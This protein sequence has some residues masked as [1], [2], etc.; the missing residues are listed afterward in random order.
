[1][2]LLQPAKPVF[3]FLKSLVLFGE[4][5]RVAERGVWAFGNDWCLVYLFEEPM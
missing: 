3:Y 5:E 1:M 4:F 2:N